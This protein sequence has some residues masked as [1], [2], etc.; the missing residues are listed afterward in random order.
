[1]TNDFPLPR[2]YRALQAPVDIRY[3]TMD[4]NMGPLAFDIVNPFADEGSTYVVPPPLFSLP[5]PP[6]PSLPPSSFLP[7][8]SAV[9]L[10]SPRTCDRSRASRFGVLVCWRRG[11]RWRGWRW[12]WWGAAHLWFRTGKTQMV[13]S[14]HS[15]RMDWAAGSTVTGGPFEHKV[16]CLHT[17]DPPR[18]VVTHPEAYVG[19]RDGGT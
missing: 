7:S 2:K 15:L 3:V 1:V 10:A 19:W 8:R 14:P 9:R 16:H 13:A 6:P 4:Y 5:T 17:S 18:A 12:W 11:W